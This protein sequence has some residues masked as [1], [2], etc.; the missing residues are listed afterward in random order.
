MLFSLI[1]SG[2]IKTAIISILLTIPIVL[3]AL[4]CHEA[5]HAYAAYK[6]GDRTAFNLGRMTINPAKHLD[7]IGTIC[8]MVFGFGWAK[9]VP[10]N[11][12]N[13]R[14][15][16]KGMAI[17]GI[18][19]PLANLALGAL[20]TFLYILTIFIQ[21]KFFPETIISADFL[22]NLFY[23]IQ[24]FFYLSAMYNFVLM[25]FNLIPVP[26]FDGSRFIGLFLPDRIYFKIMQYERY[27]FLAVLIISL[28]LSRVFGIY[29][30]SFIA[31][32]VMNLIAYPFEQLF[33]KLLF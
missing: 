17:T 18:A 15:P 25:V 31:E 3:F 27:T 12:R 4:S 32:G 6:M 14:N 9:P 19:G 24:T 20:S 23:I 28:V 2:D 11:P 16:K 29:L 5:A 22:S 7:P 30:T 1:S 33:F 21:F 8:M 13:F 10:I 26:P